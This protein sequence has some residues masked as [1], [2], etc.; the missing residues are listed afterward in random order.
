MPK[1][2]RRE[3]QYEEAQCMLTLLPCYRSY[4]KKDNLLPQYLCSTCQ[5]AWDRKNLPRKEP[6][7]SP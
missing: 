4:V 2:T 1:P 5:L 3:Y 6:P 7:A